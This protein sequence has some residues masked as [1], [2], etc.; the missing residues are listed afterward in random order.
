MHAIY[1]FKAWEVR[2]TILQTVHELD[3]KRRSY[4]HLKTHYAKVRKFFLKCENDGLTSSYGI[5][6]ASAMCLAPRIP[7]CPSI[8]KWMAVGSRM[9][10]VVID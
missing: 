4:V 8:V 3:L 7:W 5:Y 9:Q 6:R 10:C 1:H 2:N